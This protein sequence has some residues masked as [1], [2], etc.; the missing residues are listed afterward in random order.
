MHQMVDRGRFPPTNSSQSD[1][2]QVKSP[3]WSII[4]CQLDNLAGWWYQRLVSKNQPHHLL[5]QDYYAGTQKVRKITTIPERNISVIYGR[6]IPAGFT[7][8]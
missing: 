1:S 3:A 4:D 5:R 7:L 8:I 6:M 2:L